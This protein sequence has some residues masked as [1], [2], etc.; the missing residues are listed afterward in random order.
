MCS[1]VWYPWPSEL[2]IPAIRAISANSS[3]PWAKGHAVPRVPRLH[4][5][6]KSCQQI[7]VDHAKTVRLRG[8]STLH[9]HHL[10][11]DTDPSGNKH[12]SDGTL[13]LE[14]CYALFLSVFRPARSAC[15]S[16]TLTDI[17]CNYA[18][19]AHFEWDVGLT[20]LLIMIRFSISSNSQIDQRAP[21]PGSVC[22]CV[23]VWIVQTLLLCCMDL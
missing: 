19:L 3:G 23:C 16:W 21:L 20:C 22:A 11:L 2:G 13:V 17:P 6:C 15:W 7:Q 1:H 18:E 5:L 4:I 10:V 14:L 8:S 12:L 9:P